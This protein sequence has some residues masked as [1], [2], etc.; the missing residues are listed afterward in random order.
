L[1][2]KFL[3]FEQQLKDEK[4]TMFDEFYHR[5]GVILNISKKKL[6]NLFTCCLIDH[7]EN[8]QPEIEIINYAHFSFHVLQ[9]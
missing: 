2:D 8:N 4:I 6:L 5:E 9:Q 1:V 7:Q 3:I